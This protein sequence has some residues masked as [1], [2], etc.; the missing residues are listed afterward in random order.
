MRPL[1]DLLVP[2]FR[3]N[4]NGPTTANNL[5][6]NEMMRTLAEEFIP[7]LDNNNNEGNLRD[8]CR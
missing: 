4:E 2:L 3:L 7:I 8:I 5:E 6:Q 1:N